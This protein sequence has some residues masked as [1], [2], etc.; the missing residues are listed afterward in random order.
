MA[1]L[2][3]TSSHDVST[4]KILVEEKEVDPSQQ[5]LSIM[6][7]KE[8]NRIAMAA[9]IMRDGEA[10]DQTFSLSE[11]S[12]FVP[13]KTIKI[14]A[15]RD[16]DNSVF[17][18]GVIIKQ[19]ICI[20]ENG[21]SELHIE[22][23]DESIRMSIGRKS[24][25]HDKD[26]DKTIIEQLAK[27]NKIKAECED[28]R[29]KHKE[30]VQ[31]NISDWDFLLLRAEANGMVVSTEDGTVKVFR[32]NTDADPV[33]EL[34]YG[35]DV[36]EMEA[37]MDGRHQVRNIQANSW[38]FANQKA[39]K[40]ETASVKF[41]E[42]GNVSG[43]EIATAL[44]PEQY[45]LR[46][47]GYRLEQEL[48][49]WTD[50][51][52]VRS[53]LAKIRGRIKVQGTNKVKPGNMIKIS[54][55]GSR[56]N[57]NVFI[58]AVRHEMADGT[59]GTDIQFGIDPV[60]Y[61]ERHDNDLNERQAS[62]LVGSIHGL[63]VG[64]T[65][66]L[67][68]DPDGQD[69]ILVRLPS[70][71]INGTGIWTRIASLDAGEERGAFFRPEIGDEVIVGFINDDPRDAVVLGM[72]H[73]AKKPSPIKAADANNEKGFT[74]RSK[75]HISFNDDTKTISIDT[76]RGNKIILDEKG[77]KIEIEDQNQNKLVMNSSGIT[78]ES[79]GNIDITAAQTLTLKGGTSL[80]I[81]APSV[82]MKADA[83]VS[84]EGAMAKL[85]AQGIN[86]ISGLPVKIN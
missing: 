7:S 21:N 77:G 48:K 60:R 82:S 57:G 46:H 34:I 11:N 6:I 32:P 31:H 71:D 61:A 75:M 65:V 85:A 43:R 22:C 26:K 83:S 30:L 12:D 73:S 70:I 9:I 16:G 36:M 44:S 59:W 63:Q 69:R 80:S 56:F 1:D 8:I 39:F 3:N 13:G 78:M 27:R 2:I 41:K 81:G 74:T 68:N 18:K 84:I 35:T 10:A 37:E 28:T 76:P 20:K 86:E 29:L 79:K 62:G 67:E 5:V 40:A 64:K 66:Q 51:F 72:L 45:L 50:G 49:D 17:F 14:V 15:G 42:A 47:G 38:D 19:G 25:Y 24:R 4:F 58:T 23:R 52:M 53:R 54:G 33:V 55:F